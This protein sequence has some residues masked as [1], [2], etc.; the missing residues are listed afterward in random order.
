M[1]VEIEVKELARLIRNNAMLSALD[2]AGVDN[3]IGYDSAFDD[4]FSDGGSEDYNR[5]QKMSDEEVV[6]DYLDL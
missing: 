1:K 6:N 5:Y 3:W 2:C 4:E